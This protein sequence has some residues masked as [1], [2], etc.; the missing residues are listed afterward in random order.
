MKKRAKQCVVLLLV[1]AILLSF[2]CVL[3]LSAFPGHTHTGHSP[4]HCT[5][6]AVAANAGSLLQTADALGSVF[7]LLLGLI[8]LGVLF[9]RFTAGKPRH[10]VTPVT[11]KIKLSW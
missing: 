11:L 8:C 10:V 3:S 1:A 5:L 4:A 6:C 9:A 2:A 7:V